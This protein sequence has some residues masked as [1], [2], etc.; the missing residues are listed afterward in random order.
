M[1]KNFLVSPEQKAEDLRD[2]HYDLLV[3]SGDHNA[4]SIAVNCARITVKQMILEV[5]HN[6]NPNRLVYWTNVLKV[7]REI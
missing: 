6:N 3:E 5:T 4:S 2:Y 7:L 1:V